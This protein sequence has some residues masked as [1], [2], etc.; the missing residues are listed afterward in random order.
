MLPILR[1]TDYEGI[2]I[3]DHSAVVMVLCFPDNVLPQRTSDSIHVSSQMKN[4]T[5][6]YISAQNDFYLE[7]NRLSETLMCT[8]WEALKAYLSGQIISYNAGM[9]NRSGHLTELANLIN[10]IDQRHSTM[11][12][13]DL[14]KERITL[15][16]EF[17]Q[18]TST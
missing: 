5:H 1:S 2:V 16:M 4:W 15:Q 14:Y 17:Y 3:S 12:S 7:V 11:P 18:R 13:A 9:N 8:L 10:D 6:T